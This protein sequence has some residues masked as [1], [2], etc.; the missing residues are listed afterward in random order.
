[1]API[2]RRWTLRLHPLPSAASDDRRRDGRTNFILR[3]K[4]QETR[5]TL[6]EHDD[7]DDESNVEN[8]SPFH[9]H[10]TRRTL[11]GVCVEKFQNN[12]V[13]FRPFLSDTTY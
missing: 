6:Q 5:L 12:S 4:E 3:I 1:M 7:D 8:S 13:M 2:L 10:F 11:A 9:F